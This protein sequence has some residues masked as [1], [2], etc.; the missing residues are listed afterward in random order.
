MNGHQPPPSESTN[1]WLFWGD[2]N[3][4]WL[5]VSTVLITHT[6]LSSSSLSVTIL[7]N[8]L[9]WQNICLPLLITPPCPPSYWNSFIFFSLF[10]SFFSL[11]C[12]WPTSQLTLLQSFCQFLFMSW[13]EMFRIIILE[14]LHL[15][16]KVLWN[17][18][19]FL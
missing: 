14:Y 2:W 19:F 13:H 18:Y 3:T 12:N 8:L 1:I 6:I 4:V 11:L 9:V 10:L 17:D 5:Y 16:S 15:F 7:C